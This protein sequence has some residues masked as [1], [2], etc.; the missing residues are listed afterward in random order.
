MWLPAL[1]LPAGVL[2]LVSLLVIT[3]QYLLDT[4][5]LPPAAAWALGLLTIAP[6]PALVRGRPLLAWRI[7]LVGLLFGTF[8]RTPDEQVP[9]SP[10]QL[11]ITVLVL[12]VVS[13]RA[14][15]A[16]LACIGVLTTVPV[17]MLADP[18]VVPGTVVL[19]TLLLVVGQTV[20]RLRRVQGALAEQTEVTER[21]QARRAVLE[22]RARIARELHDVV[23]HH[24]SLLA[25]RA[26]TAPYRL[27]DVPEPARAEFAALAQASRDALTDMRRLLG[28]LRN[29]APTGPERA[30][31]PDLAAVADLVEAARDAGTTV[32]Y[33]PPAAD[34]L[35]RTPEAVALAGFRIVQQALANALRHA[36]GARIT[37]RVEPGPAVLVVRVDNGPPS[38]KPGRTGPDDDG[39]GHG[40]TGMR[41]RATGLGGWFTAAGTADGGFAVAA[42][43]PYAP[44][45]GGPGPE[46]EA[47]VR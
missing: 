47:V 42:T 46:G 24:M 9:W 14:D 11:L 3:V 27:T 22:E 26:E 6:L 16:V 44:P 23:A 39:G 8:N 5:T 34:D 7:T 10:T 25:V 2:V 32:H 31:Q 30:P 4:R 1:R 40:V 20:R 43:L 19:L 15:A 18:Q 13:V 33:R 21:E 12:A 37:L 41:E 38:D 45:G 28:V 36:P 29:D 17:W 35:A